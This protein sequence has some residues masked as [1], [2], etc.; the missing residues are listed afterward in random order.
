MSDFCALFLIA[1]FTAMV[2]LPPSV[3]A[4][5]LTVPNIPVDCAPPD[6]CGT[7]IFYDASGKQLSWAQGTTMVLKNVKNVAKVQQVGTGSYTVFKGRNHRLES[8][9]G[10]LKSSDS[11]TPGRRVLVLLGTV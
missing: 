7:L 4:D 6:V 3:T 10:C 5:V 9:T 8:F 2:T 11:L 1:M